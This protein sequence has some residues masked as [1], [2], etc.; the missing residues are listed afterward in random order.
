MG[1]EKYALPLSGNRGAKPE[2]F[3]RSP[4]SGLPTT[5]LVVF[6][7][8][9]SL[10][11]G[12]AWMYDEKKQARGIV[13]TKSL[14]FKCD[15]QINQGMLLPVDI[16][17]VTR[18]RMPR[19]VIS[20]GPN[21][22]FDSVVREGWEEKQSLSLRG[23]DQKTVELNKGWLEHSKYLIVYADFKGV[24]TPAY[25]QIILDENAKKH[26]NIVVMSADMAVEQ[27]HHRCLF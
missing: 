8:L 6:T 19:E 11:S 20:V 25:Q 13:K 4:G 10:F 12:C 21:Q 14:T 17:Y 5:L 16:I 23:G 3:Y 27:K 26:L 24:K 18:F 2:T 1:G 9:V 7:M 22:W 15:K